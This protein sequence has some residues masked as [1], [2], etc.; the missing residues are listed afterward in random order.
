MKIIYHCYGSSHTSVVSAAIHLGYLP[1]DR[2]PCRDEILRLPHYDKTE[3]EEIGSLFFMGVDEE[4][5]EVY[6]MGME[7]GK[8][9][10]RRAI[11]DFIRIFDI[12]PNSLY[13][14]DSLKLA[15]PTTKVGGILS[16]RLHLEALG[17]PL[18]VYGI[19]KNYMNFVKLVKHVKE[20]LKLAKG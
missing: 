15:N 2:V 17:R 8:E 12:D 16:R 3:P 18:T 14:V 4:G 11:L 1:D 5:N 20:Q 6:I 13:L 10:V 9:I 19:Q 7:N